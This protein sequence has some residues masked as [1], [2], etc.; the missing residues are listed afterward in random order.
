MKSQ[1]VM[2][3]RIDCLLFCI[4]SE[5]YCIVYLRFN[6]I[7]QI[8]VDAKP[9]LTACQQTKLLHIFQRNALSVGCTSVLICF[10]K[11]DV[12]AEIFNLSNV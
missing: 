7:L 10:H 6:L 1:T 12:L 4:V 11:C 5:G 8:S 9:C 2:P 3:N